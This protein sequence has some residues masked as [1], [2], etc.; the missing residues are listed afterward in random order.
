MGW[1]YSPDKRLQPRTRFLGDNAMRNLGIAAFLLNGLLAGAACGMD[2]K[3]MEEL[4]RELAGP[5]IPMVTHDLDQKE[6]HM[7]PTQIRIFFGTKEQVQ[8]EMNMWFVRYVRVLINPSIQPWAI[9]KDQVFIFVIYTL[10]QRYEPA[11][12][13][14]LICE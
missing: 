8:E 5:K 10:H 9:D 6:L 14:W 2:D 11:D 3:V 13:G 1:F 4:R 12:E 7:H